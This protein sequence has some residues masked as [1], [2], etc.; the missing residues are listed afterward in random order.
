[1]TQ[2][3]GESSVRTSQEVP[4]ALAWGFLA[5]VLVAVLSLA[6]NAFIVRGLG[7]HAYGVYGVFLNIARFLSLAMAMG[8]AQSMLQF[9]PEMRVKNNARGAR[10]LLWRGLGYQLLAWVVVLAVVYLVRHPLV[11]LFHEAFRADLGDILPLGAA[12]ILAEILWNTVSHIFMAVRSMRQFALATVVQKLVLVGLLTLM[13]TRGMNLVGVLLAVAVSFIA[14]ILLLA[15]WLPRAIPWVRADQGE[16]ISTARIMRY[17]LPIALGALINQVLWRSSETL[18]IGHYWLPADVTDFNT[19]YNLPQMLLEFVPLAI[20]PIVLA[21]LSEAHARRGEDLI[22]GVHLYFRLLFVLVVPVAVTGAVLG[23][24]AYLALYGVERFRGAPLCQ[25]FSLIFL[26]SFLV[27]PL[28]MALYVKEKVL[29]NTLI[30]IVGAIINV[31]LDFVFIPRYGIWGGIPPV[32]IALLLTGILQYF[33]TRRLVPQ[34][35]IPWGTFAKVLLGSGVVLPLWFVRTQLTHPVV[36]VAVLGGVTLGQFLIL[37]W[38]RVYGSEEKEM[39]LRSHLPMK[40]T[41]VKLFMG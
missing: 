30:A 2:S 40:N 13:F 3:Q 11:G 39:L 26:L 27:T 21:S 25:V 10:Q 1:V 18:I 14:G 31:A 17:A 28:R 20:W 8:I 29:V 7:E 35:K 37:R 38:L 41:L 15:P 23:G 6:S 4:S 33:V 12:L 5:K 16:G 24:Q 19:A 32:A 34:M 9:L 22:R 36:L